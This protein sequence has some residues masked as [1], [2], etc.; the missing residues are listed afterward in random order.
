[1]NSTDP[2]LAGSTRRFSLTRRKL[3]AGGAAA[4]LSAILPA[5]PAAASPQ[6]PGSSF[7]ALLKLYLVRGPDGVN[8]VRYGAFKKSGHGDLKTYLD[9][10][11]KMTPTALS[12]AGQIAFWINLYNAKTLDV[13]LDHYPVGSI[14]D[15]DL[16]GGFFGNGPWKAKLVKVEGRDH[17]LDDI[18]HDI[19][20]ARFSEPLV[21]Y[22]LNCASVGCPDLRTT[23]WRAETL[24][25]QFDLGARAYV[26]H[27]RGLRVED[28]RLTASK[29]YRWYRGDFGGA[30]GLK[31][32]WQIYAEPK[33]AAALAKVASPKSYVYDWGLNDAA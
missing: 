28:G 11:Q 4:G 16:G 7:D 9:D 24:P 6:A 12:R 23:A 14:R 33:L 31:D 3:V 21:H 5:M 17:S 29:I 20:R 26:N 10:L 30:S 8:R 19:L 18:E 32:H 13:V 15:I 25:A 2:A 27:P 22:A 1:V